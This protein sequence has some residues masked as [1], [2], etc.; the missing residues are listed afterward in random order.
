MSI[1]LS[2][3]Y[4]PMCLP[5]KPNGDIDYSALRSNTRAYLKM[6]FAGLVVHGSNGEAV[7]LTDEE[8]LSVLRTIRQEMDV[9]KSKML[10]VVGASEVGTHHTIK[11]IKAMAKEGA[12][13][14]L[15]ATPWFYTSAMTDTRVIMHYT[16]IADCSPI[17]IL[18]YNVPKFTGYRMPVSVTCKLSKHKNI[19]GIKDSGGNISK[20][21]LVVNET[22][23]E[24]FQVLAGSAGFLYP[25]LAVGAVGG[26]CALANI[27][28]EQLCKIASLYKSGNQQ[29]ALAL[30]YKL[31]EVNTYVT[32]KYGIPG[33]K[34]SLD[35]LPTFVGGFPRSPFTPLTDPTQQADM[36]ALLYKSELLIKS[37]L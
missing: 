6:P 24:N 26:V 16:T 21:A 33:L 5:F 25:A 4:P 28:G 34:Y 15:I 11:Q 27:A 8:K 10:L 22:A 7:H 35:L 3:I 18:L 17:P 9:Q 20:I 37:N 23:N 30:Q 36:R 32:A 13:L 12:D 19:I 14:A 29:E 31:I 2:G 1:D